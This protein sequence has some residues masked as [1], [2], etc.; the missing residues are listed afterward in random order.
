MNPFRKFKVW[1]TKDAFSKTT[2]VFEKAKI[3]VLFNFTF[4][5]LFLNIPYTI[6]TF[7]LAPTF[8]HIFLA[9]L[10]STALII[11]LFIL[12]K[13]GDIKW[14]VY[15]YVLNHSIQICF[16]YIVNNGHIEVQGTAF[17][18]LWVLFAYLM[19]GRKWGLGVTIIAC[20][21]LFVG[22]YNEQNGYRL[23]HFPASYGDPVGN[24][25]S[26]YLV[27]VPF[28]LNIYLVS[29]FVK[30]RQ[31]AEKQIREQKIL[32]EASNR[33][34]ELK[35]E[36]IVSSINYAK[37]IQQ[38]ILPNDET[39]QRG[40]PS[41][42]IL[43]KPRDIVS[44]D[45]YW[46]TDIDKDSY[47]M[48]V[49]DCTGHG[50]PGA[51]MTVIGSNLL[52]QIITENYVTVPSKIMS[53]LDKHITATL[54][55]EKTH[56]QIIQ[57]GMDLSLLKVNQIQKEFIYTSAK[58]PAIFIRDKQISELKG[59]KN[60]LGGLRSEEKTFDE[61]KISYREGDM[62]YLFTDGY[63]DQFGGAE[64]KKFMIR[65]LRELL[66]EVHL[67]PVS[68]QKQKLD[69]VIREWIG[70]NEQ[71]DDILIMGIRF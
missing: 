26:R 46:Y 71:T 2:D 33:E 24:P 59:S 43:Y 17:M 30:A 40:I 42:F 57:D 60:T 19:L 9:F 31:K 20:I 1:I 64:N 55:Q 39:I 49:A 54:K 3:H 61:I 45:F 35:N 36:D 21:L 14:P 22:I 6:Q 11:L 44:G 65:R 13:T 4:L 58:R 63:I 67:L 5:F 18:I 56:Q 68:G 48:V 47:I 51:F 15:F 37:R 25:A 38:A 50:V 32:L 12:K 23:F 29:E 53:E 28:L 7:R 34:L 62:L 27:I 10:T 52:T 16:H 70:N 8:A 69:D 41:S 66:L